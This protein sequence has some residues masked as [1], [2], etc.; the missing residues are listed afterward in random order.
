MVLKRFYFAWVDPSETTFDSVAHA[1]EDEKI[2]RFSIEQAEGE[3]AALSIDIKNPRV[4]L[5]TPS[6]KKWAWL[7]WG[8]V[9]GTIAPLFF[10]QLIGFPSDLQGNIITLSLLARPANFAAQKEALA[11]TLRTLPYYDPVFFTADQ[12]LDPDVVLEAR[13][14][15]WHI[16]RVTH[17]VTVSDILVG[18]D[19]VENF[20]DYEGIYDTLKI[21]VKENPLR[22]VTVDAYVNWPQTNNGPAEGITVFDNTVFP[23]CPTLGLLTAWPKI[24]QNLGGGWSVVESS[25][26]SNIDDT[27]QVT[28][29]SESEWGPGLSVFFDDGSTS[30]TTSTTSGPSPVPKGPAIATESIVKSDPNSFSNTT[31]GFYAA[32]ADCYGTLK[33]GYASLRNRNEHARFV[34]KANVQNL[35][36]EDDG[37][38]GYLV[39]LAGGDVSLPIDLADAVPI[40]DVSRNSYF[41]TDRGLQSLQYAI[42]VG[43]AALVLKSRAIEINCS[44]SFERAPDISL[45][46]NGRIFD[47]RIPGGEAL[48]KISSYVLSGD[49]STGQLRSNVT[50][51]CCIGKAG[52]VATVDGEPSWVEEG[53]VEKGWQHYDNSTVVLGTSDVGYTV[54]ADAPDSDGITFP[55]KDPFVAGGRP[56]IT[57]EMDGVPVTWDPAN[58]TNLLGDYAAEPDPIGTDIG[59]PVQDYITDRMNKIETHIRMTLKPLT[60]SKFVT[61]YDLTVTDLELPAGINLGEL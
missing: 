22:S 27:Q 19:G 50:I 8:P 36:T 41:S 20:N 14:Q 16:D 58:P 56:V 61:D 46:K 7:S 51:S 35:V 34:L 31:K 47:D 44:Y 25:I 43:R 53:W 15:I 11:E 17:V 12:R 3:F 48:G 9:G 37:D 26:R 4:G 38:P 2:I 54:P 40:N 32:V 60:G 29:T 5:L 10:G 18:E 39:T 52:T 33:I 13:S 42:L 6:R 28:S 1:R 55:V 57:F 30:T 49:G 21:A 59:P 23:N 45:R 24:G